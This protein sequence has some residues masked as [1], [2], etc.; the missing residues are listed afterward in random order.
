MS[1][2]KIIK[3]YN[4]DQSADQHFEGHLIDTMCLFRKTVLVCFPSGTC[5]LPA[6]EETCQL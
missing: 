3:D 2:Y 5:T 1:L 4:S 6:M